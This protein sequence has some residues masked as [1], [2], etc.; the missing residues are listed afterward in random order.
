[1]LEGRLAWLSVPMAHWPR[2]EL[3]AHAL[4]R[5]LQVEE[6]V[7]REQPRA[8]PTLLLPYLAHTFID[9]A[10]L[11][12]NGQTRAH[13]SPLSRRCSSLA[14]SDLCED[15]AVL[16]ALV[17]VPVYLA[18]QS[19]ASEVVCGGGQQLV[20]AVVLGGESCTVLDVPFLPVEWLTWGPQ[21]CLKW[22]ER[23]ALAMPP[24]PPPTPAMK[25]AA[26][27]ALLHL[28]PSQLA[29][30]LFPAIVSAIQLHLSAANGAEGGLKT[31][32]VVDLSRLSAVVLS[33]AVR[34]LEQT[35]AA[36][37][38]L[39]KRIDTSDAGMGSTERM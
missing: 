2:V 9:P 39:L 15:C 32:A 18:D 35:T 20:S 23:L 31:S 14:L 21:R 36:L 1:M 13:S 22:L 33:D 3:V 10:L 7:K 12:S 6:R 8:E 4:D 5:Q 27:A 16:C 26:S 37:A 25:A 19:S 28:F 24:S 11:V 30:S 34:A 38:A 29:P 17:G